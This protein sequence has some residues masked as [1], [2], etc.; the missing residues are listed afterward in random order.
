MENPVGWLFLRV[1]GRPADASKEARLRWVRRMYYRWTLPCLIVTVVCVAISFGLQ[2]WWRWVL[3][4]AVAAWA[5]GFAA[6][7]VAIQR[8]RKRPSTE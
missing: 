4:A 3:L 2:G 1:V 8:E 6:V 5:Y 7:S